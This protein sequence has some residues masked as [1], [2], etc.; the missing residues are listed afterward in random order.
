MFGASTVARTQEYYDF[1]GSHTERG[2]AARGGEE[3]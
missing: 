3:T 1:L 2:T